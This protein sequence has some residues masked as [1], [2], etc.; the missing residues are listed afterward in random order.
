[1]VSWGEI[2]IERQGLQGMQEGGMK[3][4]QRRI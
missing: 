3:A 2:L 4:I 1:M